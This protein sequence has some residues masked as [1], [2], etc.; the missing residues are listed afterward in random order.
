MNQMAQMAGAVAGATGAAGAAP[1]AAPAISSLAL[2]QQ[3][4]E[5]ENAA[6]K[7][8]CKLDS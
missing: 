2:L 4:T 5:L 3:K 1:G 6:A 8:R 7:K